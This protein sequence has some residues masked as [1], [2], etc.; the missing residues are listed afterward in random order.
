MNEYRGKHAPSGPWALSSTASVPVRRGR[1]RKRNKARRFWAIF[2]VLL[3][4]LILAYPFLEARILTVDRVKIHSEDLPLEANGLRVVYLSDIH[5]GFWY[6]DGD[7]SR[8]LNQINSLR[9]DLVLFGG[10]Y[11][12]DYDSALRFF[13]RL[14]SLPRIHARYGVFGVLGE[15]EYIS[16]SEDTR[17][18]PV[19]LSEAMTNADIVPLVNQT[20]PVYLT[21]S[22][23]FVAG[24]D[25]YISGKPNLTAVASSVKPSDFVILLAHNPSV[26]PDA[27]QTLDGSGSLGWFDLGLFGHTHGGQM[28][29]FTSALGLVDD[30]PERYVSGWLTE[31]RI[32][33]LISRGVGTSVFPAR[34]FCSPQIHLIELIA[35]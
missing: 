35:E 1:H 8:L 28:R 23:I 19:L 6:T 13:R 21:S 11:S 10:D 12:T 15:A 27:Q 30:I 17:V 9:P 3:I 20:V 31:N 26:I 2:S 18:N 25:D 14:Q 33:L 5:W 7:L 32:S 29:L 24:V 16:S 34:L 4:L 22:R